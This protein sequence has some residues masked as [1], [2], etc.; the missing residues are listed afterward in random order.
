MKLCE[1]QLKKSLRA[2]GCYFCAFHTG[3]LALGIPLSNFSEVRE[4]S[5]SAMLFADVV[6]VKVLADFDGPSI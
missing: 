4:I 6:D 5:E 2:A 3:L 1:L